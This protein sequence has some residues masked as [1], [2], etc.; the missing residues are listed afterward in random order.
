M[1][2]IV[3]IWLTLFSSLSLFT[4][5]YKGF[6]NALKIKID[7]E[8]SS[9]ILH[10][11]LVSGNIEKLIS[12]Q[13]TYNYSVNYYAGDAASIT[14]NIEALTAL[15]EQKIISYVELVPTGKKLMNDTMV[16]R[17]RLKPVKLWTAGLPRAYDGEG[18]VIGFIDSGIDFNHPDFKD[19]NGKTRVKF[20]WDQN[21][22]AGS[23][24]PQ[25]YN[26]GLEWTA[27]DIDANQCPHDD[28]AS[29]GH[30]THVA[31]IAAGNGLA[32]GTNEG[33]APKAD[34]IAVALNFF[35][36]GPTIADAVNYIFSKA[37]LLGKP[38]VINASLGDYY[39]SHDGTDLEAKLIDNMVKNIPGR[40]MVAAAGNSGN[41]KYHVKT[42]SQN[43]DTLFTWLSNANSLY[44]Y[45][46]YADT[47]QIKNIKIQVG[48][49]RINY[50]DI[51]ATGFKNY[52][53][54]L[55]GIKKDSL[56]NANHDYFGLVKS[57]ASINAYGVYELYIEVNTDT[58]G[59]LWRFETTG[60]G[61]HHSWNFDF[62]SN[63][64]PTTTQFP[65][66][67]HYVKPDS[68]YSI[69]SSFQCSDEIITVGNYNN[70][71][72]YLDVN[73]T[74]RSTGVIAQNI[75]QNS[76]HG[77]TRDGRIKPDITTTGDGIFS[78]MTM[79]LLPVFL[80]HAAN[81]VAKGGMH[82]I[83]GGTS[84]ASPVVAGLAALYLQRFPQA[85]NRQLRDAIKICSYA[86]NFT[87]NNLPN[88]Q[89]GF[90]KLDG[91]AVMTCRDGTYMGLEKNKLKDNVI[92]FPNPFTT[93]LTIDLSNFEM[94]ELSIYNLTGT[95]LFK[96]KSKGTT[97]NFDANNLPNDYRGILF[98]KISDAHTTHVYKLIKN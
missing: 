49:N 34:I 35:K 4:Q 3:A 2:F 41:V 14:S 94:A 72:H 25:P 62:V 32:N 67:A 79:S 28:D 83:S 74:V 29:Y 68:L 64:L 9:S 76:S 78:C 18:V 27:T 42:L 51:G 16:Y 26:Y 60:I 55:G 56:F 57:S 31:G 10:T 12:F 36:S 91:K 82:V 5:N 45:Y 86:D 52:N 71:T 50:S 30:G 69:V 96:D 7:N 38:C 53:Y 33:C 15:I 63:G 44:N 87:G 24:V 61:L 84:A 59:L 98:L 54:A 92:C 13:H 47:N 90:G 20:L 89:W 85:T 48:A 1:R 73:D 43:S 66:I 65:K 23:N 97:Y 58:S 95:L 6:N 39:G 8:N 40:V 77:P 93:K 21:A 75:S 17:N 70:L 37:T 11:V 81:K 46:C 19:A 22:W 80:I 88:Y